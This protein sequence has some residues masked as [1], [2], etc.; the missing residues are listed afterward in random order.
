MESTLPRWPNHSAHSGHS[1]SSSQE[2]YCPGLDRLISHSTFTLCAHLA[3]AEFCRTAM[4]TQL[5]AQSTV[6]K[7]TTTDST[8]S[9]LARRQKATLQSTA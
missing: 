2:N 9:C 4:S 5:T 3:T 1:T 8:S 7:A 6:S